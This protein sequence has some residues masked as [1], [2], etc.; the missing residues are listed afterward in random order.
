MFYYLKDTV[1][2]GEKQK[3]LTEQKFTGKSKSIW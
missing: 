3:D 2:V 1:L